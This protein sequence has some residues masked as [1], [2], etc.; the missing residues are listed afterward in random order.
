MLRPNT[1]MQQLTNPAINENDSPTWEDM[2]AKSVL[3]A[4]MKL[5]ILVEADIPI[6]KRDHIK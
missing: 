6:A 1:S 3:F 4:P 2:C 5:A